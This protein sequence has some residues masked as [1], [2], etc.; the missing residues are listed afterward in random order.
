MKAAFGLLWVANT[1]SQFGARIGSVAIPLLAIGAL[2]ASPLDMGLL[3]AAQNAGFLLVGLP[4]GAIVDRVRRRRLLLS[5]DLVRALL[6]A[7]V[8]VG[9]FTGRL[10][11]G[12]LVAV[13]LAIGVAN[14][15]FDLAQ[16]AYLPRLVGIERIVEANARLQTSNSVAVA[17]GP[18]IGGALA[19][20]LGAAG[21]VLL[22]S[23]TFVASFAALRRIHHVEPM[24]ASARRRLPAEIGEGL[25]FVL[26]DPVLRAIAL[27]TASANLFMAAILSQLVVFLV[28]VVEL[29]APAV[30]ILVASSG[31]GG[32]IGA[33]TARRWVTVLGQ[34]R[35]IWLALLV[36]QPFALLLPLAH[37]DALP[38]AFVVG[39]L[40]I[41]YGSTLYNVVQVSYRQTACPDHLLGRVQASNRFL[42]WGTMPLGGLL[43]GALGATLGPRG[44]LFVGA[45]GLI[46]ST[47][48]LTLSPLPRV[49]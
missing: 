33:A 6:L 13:V 25:R 39:W 42:A 36:T 12:A 8:P 29:P 7:A 43:G 4:V 9:A 47:F 31:V 35:T 15:C 38:L 49:G 21:T 5:M 10:T 3:N 40:V 26:T 18:G 28:R 2:A 11:L 41:G 45:V 22:T 20:L 46:A 1:A 37:R 27:C 48:W 44:A 30:G 14:A 19:G 16:Q 34:A 17:S 32:V 23:A 24:P